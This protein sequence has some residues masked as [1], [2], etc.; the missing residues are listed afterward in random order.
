MIYM[1]AKVRSVKKS[2][3]HHGDLRLTAIRVAAQIVEKDGLAALSLQAVA[4]R[5]G[6]TPMALYRHFSDKAA[7]V[8]AVGQH[9]FTILHDA[10]AHGKS[11]GPPSKTLTEWGVKYVLFA[12]AHRNLFKVMFGGPPGWQNPEGEG[13]ADRPDTAFGMLTAIMRG[14]FPPKDVDLAVLTA[15]S[16]V[17]GL[18]SLI[19]DNRLN[20]VPPDAIHLTRTVSRFFA[21]RLVA[22]VSNKNSLQSS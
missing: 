8:S 6:V 2:P 15:W 1:M 5:A 9:G 10:L 21:E 11:V 22:P 18:A 20:P 3:Y 19:V 12:R 7:L 4:S 17:H 14:L 16:F 13:L